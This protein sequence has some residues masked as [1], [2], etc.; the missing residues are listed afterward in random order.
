MPID[1]HQS[2]QLLRPLLIGLCQTLSETWIH[3]YEVQLFLG[4]L[5]EAMKMMVTRPSR[6]VTMKKVM[7]TDTMEIRLTIQMMTPMT[8]WPSIVSKHQLV[9]LALSS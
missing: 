6:L 5:G 2:L 8:I 3:L 9:R 4:K 1:P 7:A